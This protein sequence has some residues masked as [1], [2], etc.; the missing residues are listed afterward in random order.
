METKTVGTDTKKQFDTHAETVQED[1]RSFGTFAGSRVSAQTEAVVSVNSADD[2]TGHIAEGIK[3]Q[4][5]A[6]RSGTA[7]TELPPSAGKINS[8][9][10]AADSD[11]EEYYDTKDYLTETLNLPVSLTAPTQ[12]MS[13]GRPFMQLWNKLRNLRRLNQRLKLPANGEMTLENK[14]KLINIF[15]QAV[16]LRSQYLSYL[17]EFA[18][19]LMWINNL[20]E[21]MAAQP[22]YKPDPSE[23]Y[24]IKM[25]YEIIGNILFYTSSFV[26]NQ[27][28]CEQIFYVDSKK[29]FLCEEQKFVKLS[30]E[31]KQYLTLI[32][33]LSSYPNNWGRK[34][35]FFN[36]VRLFLSMINDHIAHLDKKPASPAMSEERDQF[37]SV[38]CSTSFTELLKI[39]DSNL[40]QLLKRTDCDSG[41]FVTENIRIACV[42]MIDRLQL[43]SNKQSKLEAEDIEMVNRCLHYLNPFFCK[44][45]DEYTN[46]MIVT[47]RNLLFCLE[48]IKISAPTSRIS[49]L[50]SGLS[51]SLGFTTE[52]DTPSWP[53]YYLSV[54]ARLL[55][56][57]QS[58][59]ESKKEEYPNLVKIIGENIEIILKNKKISKSELK[60]T[61][62]CPLTPKKEQKFTADQANIT[63]CLGSN[64]KNNTELPIFPAE[65]ETTIQGWNQ[66]ITIN[67]IRKINSPNYIKIVNKL[68]RL[69]IEAT[70]LYEKGRRSDLEL[71]FSHLESAAENIKEWKQKVEDLLTRYDNYLRHHPVQSYILRKPSFHTDDE[72]VKVI[73][74][75]HEPL[76][77]VSLLYS[78][79]FYTCLDEKQTEIL[80]LA[81]EA[82]S[83]KSSVTTTVTAITG[84]MDNFI[85]D[86]LKRSFFSICHLKI[87]Y[88]RLDFTTDYNK[89]DPIKACL[90]ALIFFATIYAKIRQLKPADN[91]NTKSIARWNS[92]ESMVKKYL[93]SSTI[94]EYF[95]LVDQQRQGDNPWSTNTDYM[96]ALTLL[97]PYFC[98]MPA[99]DICYNDYLTFNFDPQEMPLTAVCADICISMALHSFQD[100][101]DCLKNK[102]VTQEQWKQS[103]ENLVAI[104]QL[105]FNG[106]FSDHWAELVYKAIIP[107]CW[108]DDLLTLIRNNQIISVNLLPADSVSAV[109]QTKYHLSDNQSSFIKIKKVKPQ[110]KPSFTAPSALWLTEAENRP[111]QQQLATGTEALSPIDKLFY[112]AESLIIYQPDV[113]IEQLQT[114]YHNAI[115]Q[116]N[117]AVANRAVLNMGEAGVQIL[118]PLLKDTSKNLNNLLDISMKMDISIADKTHV[119][120]K[121]D[122]LKFMK[123]IDVT[124]NQSPSV[125][126]VIK[127]YEQYLDKV[128]NLRM[129]T[130]SDHLF[131]FSA[132]MITDQCKEYKAF[133]QQYKYYLKLFLRCMEKRMQIVQLLNQDERFHEVS[134]EK[135]EARQKNTKLVERAKQTFTKVLS[136]IS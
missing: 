118:H 14:Q 97:T 30:T 126:E 89:R 114:I 15:F 130:Q 16:D 7:I 9:F 40:T 115:K 107:P 70:V 10:A 132:K 41:R 104:A 6:L 64:G 77:R 28:L 17:D 35:A 125:C 108:I 103:R 96:Q 29:A 100:H 3:M 11:T 93:C 120:D 92:V 90:D 19:E 61:E 135:Q 60:I 46:K 73:L 109:S 136:E 67:E 57:K 99:K 113:A 85:N 72:K 81:K 102:T 105:T 69:L 25:H 134:A 101:L 2:L 53:P 45:D 33:S 56:I 8:T 22:D 47:T 48:R 1:T 12:W 131:E 83:G 20:L 75:I 68:K 116:G 74:L 49:S 54:L 32:K 59:M 133:I 5:L 86:W 55:T 18:D 122:Y 63:T 39:T 58:W 87:C 26:Y 38:I 65:I 52:T 110:P 78:E 31:I 42:Y 124:L 129:T 98:N 111:D 36:Y 66:N 43:I 119:L 34:N 24:Y 50:L 94:T 23:I 62:P 121:S 13:M 112:E 44:L 4:P 123:H 95:N 88:N 80:N 84:L 27:K 91:K 51:V 21:K 76:Q 79:C 71:N 127:N 82:I 106:S 128:I 117:N 37:E